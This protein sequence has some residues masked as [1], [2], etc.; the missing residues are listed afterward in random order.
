M[1]VCLY[2]CMYFDDLLHV[3]VDG[4]LLAISQMDHNALRSAFRYICV[5]VCV[6]QTVLLYVSNKCTLCT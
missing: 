2:V 6:Q 4:T 3:K 1:Y 5:C